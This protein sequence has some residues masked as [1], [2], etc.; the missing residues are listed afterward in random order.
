MVMCTNNVTTNS[1]QTLGG[2]FITLGV[3]LIKTEFI[4]IKML[5]VQTRT[6]KETET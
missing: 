2:E 6:I 1:T 4:V 5:K 3:V